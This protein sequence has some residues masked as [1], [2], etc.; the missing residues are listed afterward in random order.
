VVGVCSDKCAGETILNKVGS[1]AS[2]PDAHPLSIF[3]P[4]S[5]SLFEVRNRLK[6]EKQS[7]KTKLKN[8]AKF[9]EVMLEKKAFKLY[10][11]LCYFAFRQFFFHNKVM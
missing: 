4:F 6:D 7:M 1:S 9:D 2:F 8:G 3:S 11:F 5:N 10:I